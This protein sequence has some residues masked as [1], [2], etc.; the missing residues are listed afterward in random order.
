MS[1]NDAM[2]RA[3][4]HKELVLMAL[5]QWDTEHP[6]TFCPLST[7]QQRT[8]IKSALRIDSVCAGLHPLIEYNDQ[9]PKDKW[10]AFELISYRFHPCII[11][12]PPTDWNKP[13]SSYTWEHTDNGYG[14]CMKCGKELAP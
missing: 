13:M 4:K 5:E 6:G 8:G 7:L 12:M 2:R 9:R 3:G 1:Y 14:L 10:E 11:S